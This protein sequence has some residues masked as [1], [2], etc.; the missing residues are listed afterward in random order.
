MGINSKLLT[1]FFKKVKKYICTK[2][3]MDISGSKE[4]MTK[5]RTEGSTS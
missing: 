1:I 3:E 4:S 5:Q 2:R